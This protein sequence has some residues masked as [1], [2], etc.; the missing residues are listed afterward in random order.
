MLKEGKNLTYIARKRSFRNPAT[1][2]CKENTHTGFCVA[3]SVFLSYPKFVFLV[4]IMSLHLGKWLYRMCFLSTLKKLIT[5][6]KQDS[7]HMTLM[8]GTMYY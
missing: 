4:I 8:E 5:L 7:I 6:F 3:L 1:I 2:I